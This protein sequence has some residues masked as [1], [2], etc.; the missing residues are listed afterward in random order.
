MLARVIGYMVCRDVKQ[1]AGVNV[2]GQLRR[3]KAMC[4]GMDCFDGMGLGEG[5]LIPFLCRFLLTAF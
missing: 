1:G 2:E 5:M 4:M 3:G